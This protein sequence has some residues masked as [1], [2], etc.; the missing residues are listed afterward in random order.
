MYRNDSIGDRNAVNMHYGN[1][2][3]RGILCA[4]GGKIDVIR[5]ADGSNK[6]VFITGFGP[7]GRAEVSYA[8]T[9]D[10][11]R[12]MAAALLLAAEGKDLWSEAPFSESPAGRGDEGDTVR[13]QHS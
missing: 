12:Q 8:L 2:L 6:F 7:R 9:P 13:S 3:A 4:H 1:P 5:P 10:Q 11:A